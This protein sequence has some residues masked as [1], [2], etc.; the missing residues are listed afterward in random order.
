MGSGYSRR[1]A[2][3][4]SIFAA[5]GLAMPTSFSGGSPNSK[6]WAQDATKNGRFFGYHPFT[7]PLY[8]PPVAKSYAPGDPG[9]LG[10]NSEFS[11]ELTP[12]QVANEGVRH[13][14]RDVPNH[15]LQVSHG[16]APE[17]GTDSAFDP[18]WNAAKTY[19]THEQEVRLWVEETK[20]EFIPGML[21]PVFTY[22]DDGTEP[23]KGRTPGPTIIANYRAP[24]VLRNYNL[25]TEGRAGT[26]T[27]NHDH[28]TSIHL[29]GGHIPA[30]ADG[31]PD[32]YCLAGEGR[33]YFYPNTAPRVTVTQ[34]GET[35]G[36]ASH[37]S[38]DFDTTWI[39]STLWYHDHAMDVT[40]YN[41][42]RGLAGFYIVR[43]EIEDKLA[44][45][46]RI[47]LLL[48][49]DGNA[50]TDTHNGPLDFGLAL[51]DQLFTSEGHIF[52]DFLD[53][54]GRLGNVPTVNG[55]VQPYHKVQPRKYRMRFL[56]SSN[57]RY[58][59]I[60]LSNKQPMHIIGTDSWLLPEA[61]EVRRF[62]LAPGQRHD[63]VI[64]FRGAPNEVFLENI[65]FQEDGRKGKEIDA[66]KRI[67]MMKF[68]VK[69]DATDSTDLVLKNGDII[70]GYQDVDYDDLP[71]K[72]GVAHKGEWKA[73]DPAQVT[74]KRKF[75]FERSNGAWVINNQLFNPRRADAVP[76]L[77][78]GAEKWVIENS[79]GGWWH[80][81]HMHLEGFQMQ[82]AKN[83][84]IRRERRFNCDLFNL[85]DGV[86]ATFL[87]KFRSFTG[88]FVFHCHA[89]EHEDMRMMAT[90]D[91]T[92]RP[93]DQAT[94]MASPLDGER[95]IDSAVSGVKPDCIDLEHDKR[96][97]F[98]VEGDLERLDGR[99]VGFL[100]CEFDMSRRGNRG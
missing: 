88:P 48:D 69:G 13:P 1:E 33:D 27:T 80:P 34:P 78:V 68:V 3:R 23:G 53:H 22:R 21:T 67:T 7:Q 51:G 73:I 32:F 100:G 61:V 62:N 29:H 76:K 90:H 64:D 54:N 26:N 72:Y 31:Y 71:D 42:A 50:A 30:H 44:N 66:S 92:P 49:R 91:P 63:V 58:M 77:G 9:S 74:T 96:L 81:F 99:G 25:L 12:Q 35:I 10:N 93:G 60:R 86:R 87:M 28:E 16:I 8:I 57:S 45:A 17:F 94:D 6:L 39:P 15:H 55:V 36:F 75:E 11:G 65:L 52:Y 24:T 19:R 89:I 41:V 98:D 97:Y 2:L 79:S 83:T 43:S 14:N 82:S 84:R 85:T 56:N 47:P 95:K 18:P 59:E 37:S 70:R 4:W 38:G 20:Q 46:G 5:A 40:G